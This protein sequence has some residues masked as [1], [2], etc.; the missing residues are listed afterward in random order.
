MC[1]AEES[2]FRFD[3]PRALPARDPAVR[4]SRRDHRAACGAPLRRI[5]ATALL[6]LAHGAAAQ[7]PPEPAGAP[8][9]PP[10]VTVTASMG[11]LVELRR[12]LLARSYAERRGRLAVTGS[13][14]ATVELRRL[15]GW[16]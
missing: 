3:M 11:T 10:D 4:R 1:A 5:A 15:L 2:R 12:G 8:F 7:A 16:T 9:A 6:A 13:R 14:P